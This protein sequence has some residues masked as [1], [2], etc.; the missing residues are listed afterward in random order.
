MTVYQ[1]DRPRLLFETGIDLVDTTPTIARVAVKKP[2]GTTTTWACTVQTPASDGI[3]YYDV[4]A[5]DL[6]E[7]GAYL[8]QAEVQRSSDA[9]LLPKG[10]TASLEVHE[11]FQ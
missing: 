7:I 2:S 5:T 3:I 11:P 8:F 1:N 4:G 9:A 6:N 10:A